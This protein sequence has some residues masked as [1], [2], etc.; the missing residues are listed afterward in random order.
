MENNFTS[1][2]SLVVIACVL[3][4]VATLFKQ[5]WRL[6]IFFALLFSTTILYAVNYDI[7]DISSYF[8]LSYLVIGWMTAYGIDFFFRW[9]EDRL[10]WI[11][12]IISYSTLCNSYHTNN[13]EF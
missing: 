11:K 12:T 6:F 3:V 13:N 10:P 5:S 9:G 1:E 7:F 4:G 8:L 2:F